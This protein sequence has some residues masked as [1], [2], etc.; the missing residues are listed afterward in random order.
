MIEAEVE[1][2]DKTWL[3]VTLL[4]DGGADRTIF[5]ASFLPYLQ[6]LLLPDDRA[7]L[8]G[9]IGGQAT[10]RLLQTRLGLPK[11]DGKRATI[12]GL[13]AVFTDPDVT[14]F[15]ILGRDVTDNFDVIYSFP[16]RE[17]LLLAP[18]HTYVTQEPF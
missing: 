18:P 12:Q 4:L 5:A 16:K 9:G 8:L 7:L 10:S 14:D 2:A 3:P 11:S 13:F 17:V 6:P 1:L 15:C